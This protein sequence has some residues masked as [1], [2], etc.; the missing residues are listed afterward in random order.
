MIGKTMRNALLTG[1]A[2]A[3]LMGLGAHAALADDFY[4]GR[5]VE[6]I[7]STGAGGSLDAN[8]R[9]IA[10]HLPRHIPG[11]PNFIV[12]NMA[13]AGNMLAANFLFNQAPKDG[14]V[15]GTMIPVIVTAQIL[16]QAGAD[17]VSADFNWLI[18]TDYS[19]PTA[20]VWHTSPAQTFEDAFEHDVI[21]GGTGAG[22]NSV[23]YP[24]YMNEVLGTQ[25]T[26]IPG[27]ASTGEIMFAMERG[28]IDGR[29]GHSL[30]SLLME[31]SADLDNGNIRLLAQIGL[32]P[33]PRIADIPLVQDFAQTDEDRALIEFLSSDVVIGRPFLVPPGV[34]EERVQLLRDAFEA[35]MEDE[36]FLQAAAQMGLDVNPISGERVQAIV[37][38]MA[39][40][41]PSLIER[42]GTVMNSFGQ[43]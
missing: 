43:D 11:N 36:Q 9:L 5:T 2:A 3:G 16:G 41:D 29:V 35:L 12:R 14:S 7:V 6:I 24:H 15:I 19:N 27:Y 31:R 32:D 21:I 25:F 30:G 37:E 4:A 33:D 28:E 40:Q 22:S 42:A 1:I 18:S 34:P 13:G 26:I 23:L 8:A 38:N 20:Y 17:Y 10:E 39:N